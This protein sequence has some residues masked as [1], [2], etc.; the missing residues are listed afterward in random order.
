MIRG[1]NRQTV[2]INQTGNP[3]FERAILFVTPKG[4]ELSGQ[5]L[6][7]QWESFIKISDRPPVCRAASEQ[8]KK[9]KAR[10]RR[11]RRVIFALFWTVA[12]VIISALFRCVF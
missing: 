4:A 3:F 10:Y 7:S 2:E 1:V 8:R 11:I 12:G 6:K 9:Q 5:K